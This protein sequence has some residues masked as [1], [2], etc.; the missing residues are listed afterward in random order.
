MNYKYN[1]SIEDCSKDLS[2]LY[3]RQHKLDHSNAGN[4]LIHHFLGDI[5][6]NTKTRRTRDLTIAEYVEKHQEKLLPWINKYNSPDI[7][8]KSH[9]YRK[10]LNIQVGSVNIFKSNISCYIIERFNIK[11]ILDPFAGWGSRFLSAI[12]KNINYTGFDTNDKLQSVYQKIADF[13]NT[14]IHWKLINDDSSQW[15][16]EN[17]QYDTIL[18]CPP[19]YDTE[20]YENM[21]R[22]NEDLREWIGIYIA[23]LFAKAKG[24]KIILVLPEYII[25]ILTTFKIVPP[26]NE[27]ILM[28]RRQRPY[29]EGKTNKSFEYICF[30]SN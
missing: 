24:K 27:K 6:W 26:I 13:T 17:I 9:H 23:S 20:K 25:E 4:V 11:S 19:Y 22:I 3:K 5:I 8:L 29:M 30:W 28:P 12:V 16:F 15:S 21:P 10:I 1:Y 7:Q 18:S 14:R 2:L